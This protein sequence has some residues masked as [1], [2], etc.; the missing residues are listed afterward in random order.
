MRESGVRK[1]DVSPVQG[2]K[3]S[4]PL[5]PGM[6]VQQSSF[7]NV[8][9]MVYDSLTYILVLVATGTVF[10]VSYLNLLKKQ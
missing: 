3:P 10:F 8:T 2:G 1:S 4:T 6:V 7:K 9:L 5:L